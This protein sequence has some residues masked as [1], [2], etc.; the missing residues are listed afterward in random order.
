MSEPTVKIDKKGRIV[1]PKNIR[2]TAKLKEGSYVNIKT[3]GKSIIIEP[4]EPVADKYYGAFKITQWPEDIDEFTVE[5]MQK[6]WIS[7]AT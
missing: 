1:I 7:H 4:A 6:W 5:V 3:K 2:K